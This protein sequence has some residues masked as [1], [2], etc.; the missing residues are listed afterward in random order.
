MQRVTIDYK[1]FNK[2][3]F[4]SKTCSIAAVGVPNEKVSTKAV[5]YNTSAKAPLI[6]NQY[7]AKEVVTFTVEFLPFITGK[8]LLVSAYDLVKNVLTDKYTTEPF[9][10]CMHKK[11]G[12]IDMQVSIDDVFIQKANIF[13]NRKDEAKGEM[14]YIRIRFTLQGL[15]L[16]RK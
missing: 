13:V 16:K 3:G 8:D 15:G 14:G 4:D 9:T 12:S 1:H 5:V 2:A 7:N 10:I 11:D 6:Q